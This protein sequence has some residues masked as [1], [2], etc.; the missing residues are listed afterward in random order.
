[1]PSLSLSVLHLLPL[2]LLPTLTQGNP[3]AGVT[4]GDCTLGEDNIIKNYTIAAQ[5]CQKICDFDDLC[6]FWRARYDGSQCLLLKTAHHKVKP[7]HVD[8]FDC[9]RT[10]EALLVLLTPLLLTVF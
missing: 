7:C 5:G 8:Y 2:L 3:C 1:M 10:A 6:F 9:H 4:L